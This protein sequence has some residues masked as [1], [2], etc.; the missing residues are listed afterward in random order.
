MG[1]INK[2]RKFYLSLGYCTDQELSRR[3]KEIQKLTGK[4]PLS[5]IIRALL[6]KGVKS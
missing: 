5:Q 3:I 2:Q 6:W 4:A 1:S